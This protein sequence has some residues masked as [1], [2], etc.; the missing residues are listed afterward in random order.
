LL[1][2]LL[3]LLL[4]VIISASTRAES[5]YAITENDLTKLLSIL[6]RLEALNKTL[7][8]ELN[9]SKTNLTLLQNEL[10]ICKQEL[11]EL[12]QRLQVSETESKALLRELTNANT[13]LT[14]ASLSFNEY[15]QA[16]EAK[17]RKLAFQRNIS[18]FVTIITF[19][20]VAL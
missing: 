11:T 20:G 19:L 6:Q 7:S 15:K 9:T 2:P 5:N 18:I 4:L 1:L 10:T 17:I 12:E 14:K 8:E 16:A 13:L 3:S